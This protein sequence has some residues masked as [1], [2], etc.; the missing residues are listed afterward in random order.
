MTRCSEM[1]PYSRTMG[2]PFVSSVAR[3]SLI[4]G[5]RSKDA[6]RSPTTAVIGRRLVSDGTDSGQLKHI[7]SETKQLSVIPS[8]ESAEGNS[9]LKVG[10]CAFLQESVWLGIEHPNTRK[11]QNTMVN[12]GFIEL[13]LT[14]LVDILRFGSHDGT[15]SQ[16]AFS[17]PAEQTL[18]PFSLVDRNGN[19]TIGFLQF[20]YSRL[21]GG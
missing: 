10:S 6:A 8:V 13:L 4:C 3:R 16:H 15:V 19:G 7:D 2:F 11:P 1:V 17:S 14:L 12:N 20:R 9:S 21:V 18:S 5:A